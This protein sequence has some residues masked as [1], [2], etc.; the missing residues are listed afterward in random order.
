MVLS[1]FSPLIWRCVCILTGI[2][3]IQGII[4]FHELGHWLFCKLFG[5]RTPSFSI[6]FGPRLW[7][8]KIGETTFVFSAIPLGGY[9]EIAGVEEVGQGDQKEAFAKDSGS[10]AQKPYYQK[11]LV[12]CGGILFNLIFAF[13]AFFGLWFT[14]M[15]KSLIFYPEY[16]VPVIEQIIKDSPA[17]KSGLKIG[18]KIIGFNDTSISTT[19]E[20]LDLVKSHKNQT[21]NLHIAEEAVPVSLMIEA[22]PQNAEWGY[23]GAFYQLSQPAKETSFFAAL[24]RSWKL[25]KDLFVRNAEGIANAFAKK[26]A[27]GMGGPLRL[28]AQTAKSLHSGLSDLIL[29]MAMIS[30]GLAVINLLPL[31]IFDGG[32]IVTYTIEALIGRELPEKIKY[33]IH[34]ANVIALLVFILYISFKDSI[35]IWKTFF[36]K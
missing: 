27:E 36:S 32:Q 26:S 24:S 9:V 1:S 2:M 19:T 18:Q 20:L 30:I 29:L 12:L 17:E 23:L 22:H 4:A 11:L 31:P 6:G 7:S 28:F 15:P 35:Y 16:S 21:V 3:A 33:A 5:I 34:I 14:G 10:F 8:K 25:L 13:V